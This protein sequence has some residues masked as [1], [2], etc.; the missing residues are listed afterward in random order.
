MLGDDDSS[1]TVDSRTARILD[2]PNKEG[3]LPVP[4]VV[5]G[6]DISAGRTQEVDRFSRE[7]ETEALATAP[8]RA[9]TTS[10]EVGS[11]HSYYCTYMVRSRGADYTTRYVKLVEC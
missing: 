3:S 8:P 4:T 10:A 2:E 1:A 5:T 6:G 9:E 11:R 7:A